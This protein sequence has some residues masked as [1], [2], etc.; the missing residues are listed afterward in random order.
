MKFRNHFHIRRDNDAPAGGG[1]GGGP[2]PSAPAPT[3]T[4]APSSSEP[5][6]RVPEPATFDHG[7]RSSEPSADYTKQVQDILS[8]EADPDHVLSFEETRALLGY[9]MKFKKNDPAASAP[10]DP[11]AATVPPAPPPSPP[12][13]PPAPAQLHPDA[14]AIVGALK[15]VLQAPSPGSDPKSEPAKPQ[16]YYGET[17][18]ALQVHEN[19]TK[20]LFGDDVPPQA[21]QA[22]NHLVNGIAERV[23]ADAT[24]RMM[25]MGQHLMAA[26]PKMIP[27]HVSA[28]TNAERFYAKYP[29]LSKQVWRPMMG[30]LAEVMIAD[31]NSKG[32]S[33][34]DD[35]F[36]EALAN[37]AHKFIETEVGV[38]VRP[39]KTIAPNPPP[40]AVAPPAPPAP[41]QRST[42][43]TPGGARGAG[44]LPNGKGS[45]W[46]GDLVI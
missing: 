32:L 8:K 39:N 24:T 19:L 13:A 46:F 4:P 12:A 41:P 38:S 45:D 36:F 33:T 31:Y 29:E 20:A 37:A 7:P 16:R 25:A 17:V 10:V 18:P 35:K 34:T 21:S 27:T 9:P 1:G 28:Q 43:F 11:N 14:Q 26:F 3:S 40:T 2:A 23:L 5:S 6:G 44:T 42:F 22:I 30:K 15:E